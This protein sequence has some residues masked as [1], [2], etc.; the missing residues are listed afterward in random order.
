MTIYYDP[1]EGPLEEAEQVFLHYGFDE[2]SSPL[3]EEETM[4]RFAGRWKVAVTVN[5]NA[6]QLDLNFN[7]GITTDDNR[8]QNWHFPIVR[9]PLG[10]IVVIDPNPAVAVQPVT[11]TYDP[12]GREL[13]ISDK[14]RAHFGWNEWQ[15]V[16]EVSMDR[17]TECKWEV[18]VFGDRIDR[19]DMT[20]NCLSGGGGTGFSKTSFT[21]TEER[22]IA[23]I[24]RPL[25]T[26]LSRCQNRVDRPNKAAM[27]VYRNAAIRDARRDLVLDSSEGFFEVV[28][29][30]LPVSDM[31]LRCCCGS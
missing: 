28:N 9:T 20:P 8:T 26:C 22:R 18:T 23:V 6:L 7:D 12:T 5:S 14:V 3:P 2:W 17:N 13:A 10:E 16:Q 1:E 29:G 19:R 15:G 25:R 30:I 4:T 31:N 27:R 21:S 11:I 24:N